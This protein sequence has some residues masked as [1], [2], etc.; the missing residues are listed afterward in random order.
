MLAKKVLLPTE[1]SFQPS[2]FL[3][4]VIW[5]H[6]DVVVIVHELMSCYVLSEM[7]AANI[8]DRKKKIR[9][10]CFVHMLQNVIDSSC[11]NKQTMNM[12]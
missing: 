9:L 8:A 2:V 1:I 7:L 5:G 11:L 4:L 10:A 12:V 6:F 3:H